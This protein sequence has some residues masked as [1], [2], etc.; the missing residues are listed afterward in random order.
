[1]YSNGAICLIKLLFD[2]GLFTVYGEVIHAYFHVSYVINRYTTCKNY[3]WVLLR[4][5][6][7][8]TWF[9]SPG[10]LTQHIPNKMWRI[11]LDHSFLYRVYI[12]IHLSGVDLNRILASTRKFSLWCKKNYK[13]SELFHNRQNL[14]KSP[15]DSLCLIISKRNKHK[16]CRYTPQFFFNALFF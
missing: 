3:N 1:M 5:Y 10:E 9:T 11:W 7:I 4:A 15:R 14:W 13:E 16:I 2:L 6:I 8:H 12:K